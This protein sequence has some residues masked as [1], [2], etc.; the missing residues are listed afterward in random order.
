MPID[1]YLN[2]DGIKSAATLEW[3]PEYV[4]VGYG[5]PVGHSPVGDVE[6]GT[7]V[8][9]EYGVEPKYDENGNY[10]G[11]YGPYE[12]EEVAKIGNKTSSTWDYLTRQFANG[13]NWAWNRVKDEWNDIQS[14][15]R[16]DPNSEPIGGVYMS[17]I[18]P[19]TRRY[20]DRE[21]ALHYA[22]RMPN[23]FTVTYADLL[24]NPWLHQFDN[25]N[26]YYMPNT[27]IPFIERI[28]ADPRIS[29]EVVEDL[30]QLS[31]FPK[32][33]GATGAG[34]Y[35]YDQKP[36]GW[37]SRVGY[38][39]ANFINDSPYP[40]VSL[41]KDYSYVFLPPGEK[42]D[43]SAVAVHEAGHHMHKKPGL[44]PQRVGYNPETGETDIGIN[45]KDMPYNQYKHPFMLYKPN[46]QKRFESE[47]AS[48]LN[49]E[50]MFTSA[51]GLKSSMGWDSPDSIFTPERLKLE[52]TTRP[53]AYIR[54]DSVWLY[55]RFTDDL[56]VF[57][58]Y[59]TDWEKFTNF[60]NS[61]Y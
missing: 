56:A 59:I 57:A 5:Q 24:N 19:T 40:Y 52:L 50:E 42:P 18:I 28:R 26:R 1:N 14:S 41:N 4:A 61:A 53:T 58:P 7:S 38:N 55:P 60:V 39:I 51:S 33:D 11:D 43:R 20:L 46:E 34:F 37:W 45:I 25:P 22:D 29:D 27:I 10:I 12:L 35:S 3:R 16:R 36:R 54:G 17:D 2:T 9:Y 44:G 49:V 32:K 6:P 30:L 47:D 48:S 31:V 15:Q 21:Y 8:T 23:E 13:L